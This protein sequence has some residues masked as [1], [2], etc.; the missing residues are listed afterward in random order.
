MPFSPGTNNLSPWKGGEPS[1]DPKSFENEKAKLSAS[2][3]SVKWQKKKKKEI[4]LG[5]EKLR[6]LVGFMLP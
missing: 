1:G 4:L 5:S 3:K 2:T 6:C